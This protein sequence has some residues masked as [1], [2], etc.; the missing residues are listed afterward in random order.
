MRGF[1]IPRAT[2]TEATIRSLLNYDGDLEINGQSFFLYIDDTTVLCEPLKSAIERID[3]GEEQERI[4]YNPLNP[5]GY[6]IIKP[7]H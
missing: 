2:A 4:F 5:R 6:F 7:Y 1:V 3:Q